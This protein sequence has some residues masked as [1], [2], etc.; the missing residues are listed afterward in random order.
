MTRKN[1][2]FDDKK[3][4]KGNFYKNNKLFNIYDIDAD[5]ILISKKEQDGKKS[6]FK[7]SLRCSDDDFIRSLCI[8]LL[9]MIVYVKHFDSNKVM[10]FKVNNNNPLKKYTR[11]WEKVGILMNIEFDNE[12]VYCDNDKYMKVRKNS[13]GDKVNIN[14]QDKRLPKDNASYKCLSL[15]MLGYVI[16]VDK[17]FYPQ[18]FLEEC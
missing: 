9:R 12:P 17:K 6:F 16:R 18:T 4:N 7:Y 3:M 8:K 11:I 1:K 15:K 10:S 14:F 13:Y 2:I 5:K